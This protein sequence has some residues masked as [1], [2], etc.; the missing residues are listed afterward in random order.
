MKVK[1]KFV[2]VLNYVPRLDNYG[3]EWSASL[4]GRPEVDK[5]LN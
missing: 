3:G 5:S 4:P 2:P 1:G